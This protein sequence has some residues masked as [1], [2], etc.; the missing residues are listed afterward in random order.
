MGEKKLTEVP[1]E[2]KDIY[3]KSQLFGGWNK[4]SQDWHACISDIH[5]NIKVRSI[6][7]IGVG[8]DLSTVKWNRFLYTAFFDCEYFYN[9]EI[10]AKNIKKARQDKSPYLSNIHEGDV[11]KVDEV[12]PENS[13]DL[14]FWS[15]GPEHIYRK[16]WVD[17]FKKLEAVANKV[18]ILQAPWGGAYNF[19][20]HHVSK[21]I[22]KGEWEAFGYKCLYNGKED[23]KNCGILGWKFV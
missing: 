3:I 9:L 7:N 8:T 13:F 15:H 22:R 16:E 10:D 21:S 1:Q 20:P 19:S 5:D 2:I 18:V 12:W 17:T 4:Y 14:I 11:R 6:L 23:T